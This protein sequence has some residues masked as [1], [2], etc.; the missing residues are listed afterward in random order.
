MSR[1]FVY[2]VFLLVYTA[3]VSGSEYQNELTSKDED[4]YT[5]YLLSSGIILH[6]ASGK[7]R[8]EI[9]FDS[10]IDLFCGEGITIDPY[11]YLSIIDQDRIT[12]LNLNIHS[13]PPPKLN[14][15]QI[16][17]K[18]KGELKGIGTL[19][20]PLGININCN[21]LKSYS[22]HSD[23][24]RDLPNLSDLSLNCQALSDIPS[25]L[26]S[27]E[28]GEF[29]YFYVKN[30]ALRSIHDDAVSIAT[31][32]VSIVV[33]GNKL[34]A[35]FSIHTFSELEVLDISNNE[36]VRLDNDIFRESYKIRNLNISLNNLSY[37]PRS[38]DNLKKLRLL[39]AQGNRLLYFCPRCL[40]GIL[41]LKRINLEGNLLQQLDLDLAREKATG[42]SPVVL[43]TPRPDGVALF[44]IFAGR[45]AEF[46]SLRRNDLASI[47]ENLI[48]GL[49]ELRQFDVSF[50]RLS[51]IPPKFLHY[52][53]RLHAFMAS[54]N[55]ISNLSEATLDKT[56]WLQRLD[57]SN[58]RI[59][60]L[61]ARFFSIPIRLEYI[62]LSNNYIEILP[63][64]IFQPF[65]SEKWETVELVLNLEGNQFQSLPNLTLRRL[66]ELNLARNSLAYLKPETLAHVPSLRLIN[67]SY[68]QFQSINHP[69]HYRSASHDDLFNSDTPDLFHGQL[70][71]LSHVDLSHNLLHN[72]PNVH[73]VRSSLKTL[74]L[75]GNTINDFVFTTYEHDTDPFL[76]FEALESLDMS[77]NSLGKA[78]VLEE[79]TLPQ[80]LHH[81][82][83]RRLKYLDLSWNNLTFSNCL[84]GRPLTLP[85]QCD[86]FLID[87]WRLKV[88]DQMREPLKF[89][90]FKFLTLLIPNT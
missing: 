71:N 50:N 29:Y 61:G 10:K 43:A 46:L 86:S 77:R 25:V 65:E 30:T 15:S 13:C 73:H 79:D 49:E 21:D 18:V 80:I 32:M 58:N 55:K 41:Y 14:F 68:N 42:D 66:T 26:L 83:M 12:G 36:I 87:M 8:V 9:D 74:N 90:S 37:L 59:V 60:T 35:M 38:L 16:P 31:N 33:T 64:D 5:Q 45:I 11:Q 89:N 1:V 81:S 54:H 82:R 76:N 22:L 24:F 62:D 69:I 67:L 4:Y 27:G 39:E 48:S 56:P 70:V 78:F 85:R 20:V 52:N 2:I 34:R 51:S 72:F 57:L 40:S 6:C 84:E 28:C 17:I 3:A 19:N 7:V 63:E 53:I 75:N 23:H 47:P 88:S 44:S